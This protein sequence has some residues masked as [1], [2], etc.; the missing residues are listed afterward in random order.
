ML[1]PASLPSGN[2]YLQF[3]NL[4]T[5]DSDEHDAWT[6]VRSM[7][8]TRNARLRVRR[9]GHSIQR[10]G[11]MLLDLRAAGPSGSGRADY[12]RTEGRSDQAFATLQ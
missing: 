11:R 10:P 7:A 6:G 3:Q 9:S 4:F 1:P 2:H 5:S 12:Y 8:L